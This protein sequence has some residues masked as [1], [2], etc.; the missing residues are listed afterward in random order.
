MQYPDLSVLDRPQLITALRE[1]LNILSV[2]QNK[3][4]SIDQIKQQIFFEEKKAKDIE[5]QLTKNEFKVAGGITVCVIIGCL[6]SGIGFLPALVLAV[7][8]AW[9]FIGFCAAVYNKS[10][11]SKAQ[12]ALAN[13]YRNEHIAPLQQKI[14][15]I[16]AEIAQYMQSDGCRWAGSVLNTKYL[17]MP[18]I[19]QLIDFLQCG[20]ADSLKEALNLFEEVAYRNRMQN[21]QASIMAAAQQT[22]YQSAVTAQASLR[23][24]RANELTADAAERSARANEQTANEASKIRKA[25]NVAAAANVSAANDIHRMSRR[26]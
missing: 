14:S 22:A 16:E 1:I 10:N 8:L 3:Y 4:A 2:L 21:M 6:I 23:S 26:I 25:S 19:N 12:Q 5:G 20:R 15:D 24:A 13:Q 7:L 11:P 17:D 18:I 9:G